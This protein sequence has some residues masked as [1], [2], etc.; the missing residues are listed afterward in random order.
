MKTNKELLNEKLASL[1]DALKTAQSA[2]E[3]YFIRNDENTV[4]AIIYEDYKTAWSEEDFKNRLAEEYVDDYLTDDSFRHYID[5]DRLGDD[6]MMDW[7]ELTPSEVEDYII[8]EMEEVKYQLKEL[9]EE[10]EN[11]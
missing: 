7:S 8:E 2:R 3:N 6:L 4:D 9:D 5:T 1:E 11:E 10:G